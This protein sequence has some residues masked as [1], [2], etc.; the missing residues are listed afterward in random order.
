[1][2]AVKVG[3][4]VSS[5]LAG[6]VARSGPC[7]PNKSPCPSLHTTSRTS[8]AVPARGRHEELLAC[9]FVSR[10]PD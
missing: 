4:L 10:Y 3:A 7:P 8:R 2:S 9:L 1:M 5:Q 6:S